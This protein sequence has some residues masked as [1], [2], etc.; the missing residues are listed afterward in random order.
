V[1][2]LGIAID[3]SKNGAKISSKQQL[4]PWMK[5]KVQG[6]IDSRPTAVNMRKEG[7][8]LL[9][10]VEEKAKVEENVENLKNEYAPLSLAFHVFW[11]DSIRS[12]L[13]PF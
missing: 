6:L 9:A 13:I 1:G 3:L 11:C 2:C 4:L 8:R 12:Y 10:F 5:E 7:T